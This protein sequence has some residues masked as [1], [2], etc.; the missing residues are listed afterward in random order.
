M[1]NIKKIQNIFFKLTGLLLVGFFSFYP[2]AIALNDSAGLS[3]EPNHFIIKFKPPAQINSFGRATIVNLKRR[4]SFSASPEFKNIY[5]FDSF[6]GLD[7][8]RR[9]FDSQF[10]FLEANRQLQTADFSV[11]Q[12]IT[13]NDPGFTANPLDADK[14]WGLAKAEFLQAWNQTTGSLKNVVAVIDTGADATHE[15]LQDINWVGG[16]NFLTKQAISGRVNSDDNS[17]GTLVV[18]ILGA[19]VN[20]NF[21]IAGANWKISIMP[22]KALNSEGKGEAAA[23]AEAIVWATDN[24][25][26]IINLSIGGIGF[27][28]DTNLANA[29]SYAFGNNVVLVAAAGNDVATTGGNLDSEPVYPICD[30]NNANMV[31]GVSATDH[32]DVKPAFSNFGRNCIDVSAPGKRILSAIN[33]DPLTKKY[34]PNSY[35]YASGTSLA[36]P[37]VVAQAALIKSMYPGAS[38]AQIRDR[39]VSTADPIDDLNL[40]QCGGLSCRGLIGSGRINAVRSLQTAIVPAAAEGDLVKTSDTNLIYYISGGQ[41]HI[42][43]PFVINQRFLGIVPKGVDSSQLSVFPEGPYALPVE[44][45]LVKLDGQATVFYIFNGQKLPVT[46]AVFK[47]RGFVFSRM[48]TV[49]Y[50]ELVSWTT[51]NFLAPNEGA[52]LRTPKNKTV[53]WVVSGVLHPINYGFYIERGLNVFPVF[54]VPDSDIAGFAKGEA[55][56]K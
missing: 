48:N 56:I 49:S 20:N 17:H 9:G 36:V 50:S 19:T 32:N 3:R 10:E 24:K 25:A 11:E 18:G 14:Q 1:L 16:Y 22:L 31:I 27:G 34:S 39:I 15:D 35:A 33:Y 53:Y 44:G 21:G 52:L 41:K 29:I 26:T 6:L 13:T 37:F 43:S 42:V 23:I 12:I 30:D 8:L 28:H 40:I 45:T 47:Q 51:G 5:T 46:A 4:Y 2:A 55:Y 38:N 7:E 54:Y